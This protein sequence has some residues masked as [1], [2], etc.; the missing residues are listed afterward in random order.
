MAD[1]T[2]ANP[3]SFL[4]GGGEMGS[5]MRSHDWRATP[6][7]PPHPI[8]PIALINPIRPHY[9]LRPQLGLTWICLDLP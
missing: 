7:G 2:R 9:A 6:L 4:S 5:L 3:L 1:T 8:R